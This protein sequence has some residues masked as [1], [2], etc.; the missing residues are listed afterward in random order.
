MMTTSL[1][2]ATCIDAV[3][4]DPSCS[5]VRCIY[6]HPCYVC[7]FSIFFAISNTNSLLFR[8]AD[9]DLDSTGE[10]DKLTLPPELVSAVLADAIGKAIHACIQ[11]ATNSQKMFD[12]ATFLEYWS[13]AIANL[14][15]A[16]RL[17]RSVVLEI[18]AAV[19]GLDYK[20]DCLMSV[21]TRPQN[22]CVLP[23]LFLLQPILTEGSLVDHLSVSMYTNDSVLWY[24]SVFLLDGEVCNL[25]RF[26]YR[27]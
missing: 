10:F 12:Y 4:T 16:S 14:L 18:I 22:G 3:L 2:V 8:M 27:L 11:D 24:C 20:D 15:G 21:T 23:C 5:Y 19:V 26:V 13:D 7:R 6:R 25:H 17:F 1:Y 9:F